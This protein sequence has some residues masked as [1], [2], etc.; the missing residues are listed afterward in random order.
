LDDNPLNRRAGGKSI[1]DISGFYSDNNARPDFSRR[2]GL[3]DKFA[4][5]LIEHVVGVFIEG[6]PGEPSMHKVHHCARSD[7][8]QANHR[9][10]IRIVLGWVGFSCT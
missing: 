7:A 5:N 2:Q 4:H 9:L 6:S 8:P 3:P 10:A 1:H